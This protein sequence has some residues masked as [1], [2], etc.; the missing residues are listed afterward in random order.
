VSPSPDRLRAAAELCRERHN[1]PAWLALTMTGRDVSYE[2]RLMQRIFG[3]EWEK[4]VSDE[5]AISLRIAATAAQPT[6]ERK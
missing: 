1:V 3:M 6:G 5:A 4:T 2:W